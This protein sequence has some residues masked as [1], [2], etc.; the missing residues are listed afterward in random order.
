MI[1]F[2]LFII[3]IKIKKYYIKEEQEKIIDYIYNNLHNIDIVNEKINE[4]L[5]INNNLNREM[6][7][8]KLEKDLIRKKE[9]ELYYSIIINVTKENIK[10]NLQ[11]YKQQLNIFKD[12][13]KISLNKN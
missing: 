13:I 5:K 1:L 7:L 2:I 10:E 12:L 3:I 8:I 9:E 11:T 4:L 6:L